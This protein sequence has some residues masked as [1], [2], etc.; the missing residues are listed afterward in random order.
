MKPERTRAIIDSFDP[1][2]S[3]ADAIHKIGHS[4]NRKRESSVGFGTKNLK[5]P[6]GNIKNGQ[7]V[8]LHSNEYTLSG[9]KAPTNNYGNDYNIDDNR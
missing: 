3:A 1:K 2:P 8:I 7:E 9:K 5:L 4:Y 6:I